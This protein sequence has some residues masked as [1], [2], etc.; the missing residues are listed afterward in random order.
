MQTPNNENEREIVRH[1]DC[2]IIACGNTDG[3]GNGSRIYSGRNKLDGA[4]LDRFT[5]IS[6]EYDT[7]L[8]KKLAG[9]HQNLIQALKKLRANVEN[10][11]INRPVT[12]RAFLKLGKWMT[13]GKSLKYCLNRYTDGWT[14][15]EKK[16]ANLSDIYA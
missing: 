7:A 4:T 6:F 13:A 14:E 3:A 16:K 10:F 15:Y 2:Y 8:E 5:T 1:K 12:T 9:G 11:E